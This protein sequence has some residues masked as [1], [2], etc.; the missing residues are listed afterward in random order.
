MRLFYASGHPVLGYEEVALFSEM[1]ITVYAKSVVDDTEHPEDCLRPDLASPDDEA[2]LESCETVVVSS[3]DWLFKNWERLKKKRVVWRTFGQSTRFVEEKLKPLRDQ[4][5]LIVRASPREMTIDG[6]LGA[7]AF[8]RCYK[9]PDLFQGWSGEREQI[10]NF[11]RHMKYRARHCNFVFLKKVVQDLPF[12]LFG[13]QNDNLGEVW[14]SGLL[15]FN[16]LLGELRANRAY[17]HT[18]VYPAGY[19][20]SF[21]EAWMTGIPVVALDRGRGNDPELLGHELYEIPDL[22]AHGQTG[23]YSDDETELRQ[24]FRD[25]L[26]DTA[27][28]SAISQKGREAAIQIFGK[29]TVRRTWREFWQNDVRTV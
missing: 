6:N 10:I 1:G 11:T 27:Y 4:G 5:L 24:I 2:V 17:F 26:H 22:I 29:E 13:P 23:F 3:A 9:D 20:L 19:T 28:A 12:R 21:V 14:A 18:G 8:I 15:D 7:D 25:L 16:E